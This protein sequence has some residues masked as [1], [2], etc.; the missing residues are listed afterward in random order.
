MYYLHLYALSFAMSLTLHV[1]LQ[2]F[3]AIFPRLLLRWLLLPATLLPSPSFFLLPLG[4]S[5]AETWRPHDIIQL[6]FYFSL[7]KASC[8]RLSGLRLIEWRTFH[9]LSLLFNTY[10][11]YIHSKLFIKS[12]QQTCSLSQPRHPI[13]TMLCY[14]NSFTQHLTLLFIFYSFSC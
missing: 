13:S 2:V 8:V 10:I 14:I 1:Y 6:C 11:E 9:S 7:S 12:F 3:S 4:G 5:V